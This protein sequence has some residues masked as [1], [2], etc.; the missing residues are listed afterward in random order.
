MTKKINNRFERF[1][2]ILQQVLV[3]IET[4]PKGPIFIEGYAYAGK[5]MVFN[6]GELGGIVKHSLYLLGYDVTE[7]APKDLK[8]FVSGNG[9]ADKPLM[10]RSVLKKWK[11]RTSDDNVADAIGLAKYGLQLNAK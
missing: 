3:F 1:N 8:K 5:G 4:H 6:I 11:Y 9:N 7:M 10:I 2:Y